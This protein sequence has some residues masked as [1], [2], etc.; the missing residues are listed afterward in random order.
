MSVS[1]K[2]GKVE[3]NIRK[4]QHLIA[5][6][7]LFALI[8][9]YPRNPRLEIILAKLSL[10]LGEKKWDT[11]FDFFHNLYKQK[12][13]HECI[14]IFNYEPLAATESVDFLCLTAKCCL[15][16]QQPRLALDKLEL[17]EGILGV[18]VPVL[19]DKGVAYFQLH[20][21]EKEIE[22]Y[23]KIL[24]LEPTHTNA[25][26]NALRSFMDVGDVVGIHRILKNLA[27]QSGF[28]E[29]SLLTFSEAYLFVGNPGSAKNI[30]YS[31]LDG[32]KP[33][34]ELLLNLAKANW[35][36]G[37]HELAN[38]QISE[39]ISK[40]F[41]LDK[42]LPTASR[43]GL[44]ENTNISQ[45]FIEVLDDSVCSEIDLIPIKFSYADTLDRLGNYGLAFDVYCEANKLLGKDSKFCLNRYV[46]LSMSVRKCAE[47]L[48][49][50]QNDFLTTD[51]NVQPI[52]II[53]MP[54]SGSTL[55][56]QI[57]SSHSDVYAGDELSYWQRNI[58]KILSIDPEKQMEIVRELA[59]EYLRY[60]R[61]LSDGERFVT[62]K[63]PENF[64]FIEI[65][66]KIFPQSKII[67]VKRMKEATCWSIFT[68]RFNVRS[69]PYSTDLEW[70]WQ[71]YS[72]YDEYL[73]E[74]SRQ[75]ACDIYTLNYESL[76]EN[77]E[78][79]TLSLLSFCGL[80]FEPSCINFHKNVRKSRTK[81]AYQVQQ[82][83]Y[84]GSSEKWKNYD[85]LLQGHWT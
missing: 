21:S 44:T 1:H 20:N 56:E 2:I 50:Y 17:V 28:D 54:R 83:M 16:T 67:N 11:F 43:W 55:T 6:E 29:R 46:Q 84:T 69:Y 38:S 70:V 19:E 74:V 37:L 81:S 52:F 14:S 18:S 13:Y 9:Q 45:K 25:Q 72:F 59:T 4:N 73:G 75:G 61:D 24:S 80:E 51:N 8:L 60:L 82:K 58:K 12:Q 5:T 31:N 71:F 41:R 53:G 32:A 48:H 34:A 33:E 62:D 40:N 42:T 65:L 77:Q 57:L 15:M 7:E 35:D 36:L 10:A 79:E 68:S 63:M 78:A 47:N 27:L 66:S 23:E 26:I 64:L 30:I 76:T 39:L 3:S 22:C 49:D 85:K